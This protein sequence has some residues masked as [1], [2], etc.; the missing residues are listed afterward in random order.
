M[1]RLN[2]LLLTVLGFATTALLVLAEL[3]A[4]PYLMEWP[5][6]THDAAR[7]AIAAVATAVPLAWLLRGYPALLHRIA[8]GNRRRA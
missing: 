6:T 3:R 7:V 5:A 1:R 2:V 8:G 4:L